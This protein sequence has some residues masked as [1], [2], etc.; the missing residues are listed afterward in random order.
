MVRRMPLRRRLALL[1]VAALLAAPGT[2]L[3]QGGGAG[4]DQYEDPFAGEDQGQTQRPDPAPTPEPQSAAPAPEAQAPAAE[5]AQPGA[6]AQAPAAAPAQLPYTGFDPGFVLGAGAVL[7]SGGV[8][9][10]L[11]VRAR[12]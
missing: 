2:A 1:S 11:R 6:T 5:P 3:A 8:A 7:L 10:R 4:D 9:L 12:P